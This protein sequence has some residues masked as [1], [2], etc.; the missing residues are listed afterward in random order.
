MGQVGLGLNFER[1][2]DFDPDPKPWIC[3]SVFNIWMYLYG[4][5]NLQWEITLLYGTL[6]IACGKT[7]WH[8]ESQYGTTAGVS[9]HAK[10]W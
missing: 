6:C 1:D 5:I 7:T 10:R 2:W 3:Y 8:R 9:M 4:I